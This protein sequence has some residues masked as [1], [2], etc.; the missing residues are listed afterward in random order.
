MHSL[1]KTKI[2]NL[3]SS[4]WVVSAAAW[5][6]GLKPWGTRYWGSISTRAW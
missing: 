1:R 2:K 6:A 3:P 4:G 5:R